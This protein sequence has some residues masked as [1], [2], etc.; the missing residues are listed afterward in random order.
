MTPSSL[1]QITQY[2]EHH[3]QSKRIKKLI[4]CVAKNIWEND[5]SQLDKF[6]LSELIQE[7]CYL[8]PSL[9]KLKAS[10]SAIVNT[11]NKP[12][13]YSMIA[14]IITNEIQ[15]LYVIFEQQTDIFPIP[16]NLE[17]QTHVIVNQ[18]IIQS[19]QSETIALNTVNPINQTVNIPK[20]L[21]YNQFDVRQNIM[22]YTNPLRAKIILFSALHRKF[23][24]NEQDWF[25]LRS[26]KLDTLL[27]KLFDSCPTIRHFEQKI[28]NAVISLG[29][30][31]ENTQA[32]ST[33]IQFIKR[34]YPEIPPEETQNQPS[35]S[36]P[37]LEI[38]ASPQSNYQFDLSDIDDFYD[39]SDEDSTC[40]L[41]VP[42]T[43][44]NK[45]GDR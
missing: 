37:S 44:D 26:Q 45:T 17:E 43:Q 10:L 7:L 23:S 32:G 28:N 9:D 2:L 15:K 18:P 4:F 29:D 20:K 40:Q 42:P 8:N 36:N 6:K 1:D 16:D 27:Q 34:F 39:A 21:A 11:L 25:K 41:I 5:Q 14:S 12:G 31:E 30:P 19:T 13:E 3:E 22:Q 24:F 38:H 35:Y 33:L